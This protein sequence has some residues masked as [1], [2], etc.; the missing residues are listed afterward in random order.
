MSLRAKFGAVIVSS[1]VMAVSASAATI[2]VDFGMTNG[3]GFI[4]SAF[5]SI[6]TGASGANGAVPLTSPL[7]L[8]GGIFE[9]TAGTG[10]TLTCAASSS[11]N[12][13]CAPDVGSPSPAFGLGV[14]AGATNA[15]RI[16]EG[17][18]II[19]TLLNPAYSAQIVS[20]DVT[21]FST[22]EQ[23]Q[24]R[25]DNGV[26]HT[27]NHVGGATDPQLIT[28]TGGPAS[29]TNTVTWSV[30]TG[31]GGNYSL[32]ILTLNYTDPA[33]PEPATFGLAGLVLIGLGTAYRR[34]KA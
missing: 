33:V 13:R 3:N 23:G 30:P 34:K 32:G 26:Q 14:G 29:F 19:L 5:P 28:V 1:L 11:S 6:G 16:D 8:L 15:A 12:S 27:F 4:T 7:M 17:E 25:I 18:S 31:N 22:G 21:G 10:E 20:F 2:V 24:Y 9:I